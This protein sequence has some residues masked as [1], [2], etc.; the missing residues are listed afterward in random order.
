MGAT[1]EHRECEGN[2]YARPCS[3]HRVQNSDGL[4]CT[5]EH[6]EI[7]RRHHGKQ[8]DCKFW[9]TTATPYQLL[10]A[11][12]LVVSQPK[13]SPLGGVA[14]TNVSTSDRG[15]PCET[16]QSAPQPADSK[17]FATAPQTAAPAHVLPELTLRCAR[18]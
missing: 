15:I 1:G 8:P 5:S 6:P 13:I 9:A 17:A 3:G 14:T 2:A 12:A 10:Y 11:D 7:L 16:R 4:R 18:C